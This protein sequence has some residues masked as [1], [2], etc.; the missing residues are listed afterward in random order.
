MVGLQVAREIAKKLNPEQIIVSAL[1]RGEVDEA[2]ST[3]RKEGTEQNWRAEFVPEAG[4]IFL[5]KA[6][7]GKSRRELIT[8]RELFA[9]LFDDIFSS[10]TRAWRTS[11]INT[12]LE[13]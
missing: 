1:T 2:I 12:L 7:K 9:A 10:D 3:L 11:G 6:L 5:P 8:D 4:D 13:Q